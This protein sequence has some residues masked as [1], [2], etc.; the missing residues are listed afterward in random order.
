MVENGKPCHPA[1]ILDVGTR[2][3][4]C[5]VKSAVRLER[6]SPGQVMVVRVRWISNT[7]A[8]SFLN[9]LHI[10]RPRIKYAGYYLCTE[11]TEYR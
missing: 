3:P 6:E 4:L 2:N 9:R 1:C 11:Y 10:L 7:P 8:K 5:P